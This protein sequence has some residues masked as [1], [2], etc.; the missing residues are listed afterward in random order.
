MDARAQQRRVVYETACALAESTTLADAAPRML[1]AICEA[2]GW[3]HGAL[4]RVEAKGDHLT[5]IASWHPPAPRVEEFA[6]ISRRTTLAR[7]VRPP[8]RRGAA[9]GAAGEPG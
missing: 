8:G 7:G 1:E 6:D 3:E 9:G 2:L 4:W 5:C